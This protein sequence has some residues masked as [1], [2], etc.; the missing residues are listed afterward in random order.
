MMMETSV[1]ARFMIPMAISIAFG[2]VF[3]SL[4]TL[5][6]VPCSYLVLEDLL[7]FAPRLR[8]E[9]PPAAGILEVAHPGEAAR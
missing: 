5:F 2:V 4:I 7:K 3:A 8:T 1:Q 9:R 6:L